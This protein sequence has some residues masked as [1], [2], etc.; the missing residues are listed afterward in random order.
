MRRPG[1]LTAEL[2]AAVCGV[3][4]LLAFYAVRDVGLAVA[5]F[6]IGT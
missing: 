1:R 2:S 5:A 3:V 6:A 4:D